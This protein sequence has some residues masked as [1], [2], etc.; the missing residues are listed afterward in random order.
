MKLVYYP[1][2]IL[3][4]AA[5]PVADVDRRIK[6]TAEQMLEL[7]HQA[8][9]IGLAGPQVGLLERLFV[10]HVPEDE[11][12]V[13]INPRIVEASLDTWEYEEGCLSIP[14]IYA[15]I[16]RPEAITVEAI[17]QNGKPLRYTAE[18]LLARVIQHELDHL[19]GKLFIEYLTPRRQA[20]IMRAYKV[21]E[22]PFEV[23]PEDLQESESGVE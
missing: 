22:D 18:G 23:T 10:V 1:D 17:D 9:G 7:M 12:R 19:D 4:E 11:P 15:N 21:P 16:V 5:T 8:R 2:E 20:R 6:E 3:H 14:K 13:F